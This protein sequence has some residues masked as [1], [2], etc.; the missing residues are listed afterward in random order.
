MG[1][2]WFWP[3]FI[4]NMDTQ[5]RDK[6]SKGSLSRSDE[7]L[8]LILFVLLLGYGAWTFYLGT[9]LWGCFIAG[10]SF[11]DIHHVHHVW[12]HQTKR[13]TAWMLRVFFSCTVAFA[14][15]FDS[16]FTLQAF[17]YGSIMG[18]VACITTKVLA[19]ICM[20][21]AKFVIGWAMV[22]R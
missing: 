12:S 21:D 3:R 1:G 10:M 19:G 18:V 11:A 15:P 22:G 9:H 5:L 14:I 2:M 7:A 4:A 20:G 16:L 13:L 6:P 8:L 17:G